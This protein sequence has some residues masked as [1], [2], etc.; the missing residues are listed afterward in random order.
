MLMTSLLGVGRK[1]K[2]SF[3]LWCPPDVEETYDI[4]I[5]YRQASDT[6]H[7]RLLYDC[8]S[9]F[10][11]GRE[12]RRLRVFLDRERLLPGYSWKEGF[13]EGLKRSTIMVPIVSKGALEP[14][15]LANNF[16][17]G[18]GEDWCDNV[19]LEWKLGLNLVQMDEYPLQ[20]IYPIMVGSEDLTQKYKMKNFFAE[21]SSLKFAD[22]ASAATDAELRRWLP[23]AVETLGLSVSD[24]KARL[25]E[26]QGVKAWDAQATHGKDVSATH[27]DMHA[28]CAARVF[29]VL[30]RELSLQR[31]PASPG[32][33]TTTPT[34]A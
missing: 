32:A 12:G 26:S 2:E 7:A 15:S 10:V 17:P 18:N 13:V 24:T 23:N 5:S 20:A 4:F 3:L 30:K 6:V 19:L 33:G 28:G 29:E 14:M 16:N 22:T 27:F 11:W 1:E 25:L 8:L 31:V 34:P 9:K 21:I